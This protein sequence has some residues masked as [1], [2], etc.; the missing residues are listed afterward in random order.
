MDDELYAAQSTSTEAVG[1]VKDVETRW[2]STYYLCK[3]M[4]ELRPAI[5]HFW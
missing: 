4:L 3:R 2:N 1:L 5:D